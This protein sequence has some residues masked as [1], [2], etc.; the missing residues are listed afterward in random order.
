VTRRVL[1]GGVALFGGT[2]ALAGCSRTPPPEIPPHPGVAVLL[3]AIATE[4]QLIALY[5]STGTSHPE[6]GRRVGPLLAHHREHLAVLRRHYRPGTGDDDAT[7][8][9][10]DPPADRAG[11]GGASAGTP[12]GAPRSR[13]G[14]RPEALAALR[15]AERKAAAARTA[16]VARAAPGMAQLFASI[17]A[18][19]TGHLTWLAGVS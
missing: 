15:A 9:P 14:S 18:C 3:R 1:L 17:A 6:L 12:A 19:E 2:A 7:A 10:A 4:E 11:P 13:P 5:E 8:P 16:D